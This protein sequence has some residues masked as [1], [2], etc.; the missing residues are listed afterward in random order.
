MAK[1]RNDMMVNSLFEQM[2][3]K[4]YSI[5]VDPYEGVVL[6]ES[7]GSF[8]CYPP[9]MAA[10]PDSLYAMVTQMNVRCAMTVNTHVVRTI[11]NGIS[12]NGFDFV[13]LPDGLRVQIIRTMSD[14]PKCQL[15]QFAAFIED[16]KILVVW[17]DEPDRILDWA[18]DLEKKLIE[19]I[20]RQNHDDM[21][22]DEADEKGNV[23][24]ETQEV[25]GDSLEQAIEKRPV[26]LESACIVAVTMVL[27]VSCLGLGWRALTVET[28]VDGTYTRLALLV[29][30]P[31]QFFVSLV[32]IFQQLL[33]L[34]R[35]SIKSDADYRY[36]SSS[37]KHSLVICSR[38]SAPSALSKRTANTTAE[39]HPKDST[40]INTRCPMLPFR[41]PYTKKVL[42]PSSSPQ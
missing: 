26:R 6:K 33:L 34:S 29:V 22:E 30:F 32:R 28:M 12:K 14:L 35:P 3:R 36:Y 4:Q 27:C 18:E 2:C 10:F 5:G 42:R 38:S 39:S 15:H 20:W 9:Q 16:A 7:R 13:P 8:T 40:V 37:S 11:L 21:D 17:A 31:V 41:C 25:D 19:L 1:V 23:T 24:T